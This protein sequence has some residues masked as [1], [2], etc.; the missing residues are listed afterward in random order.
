VVVRDILPGPF[1]KEDIVFM[2][3]GCTDE[4]TSSVHIVECVAETTPF[5]ASFNL[6]IHVQYRGGI[7]G[8]ISNEACIDSSNTHDPVGDNNFDASEIITEGGSDRPGG[9]GGGRGRGGGRAK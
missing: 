9:P 1:K 7:K 4:S 6:E 5:G 2:S 8:Q 3:V